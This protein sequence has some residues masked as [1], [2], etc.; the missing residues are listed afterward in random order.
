MARLRMTST[1]DKMPR[2]HGDGVRLPVMVMLALAS[3]LPA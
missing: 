3:W 2:A 1:Q